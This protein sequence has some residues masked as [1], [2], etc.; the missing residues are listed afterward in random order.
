MKY[1]IFFSYF[2]VLFWQIHVICA[3]LTTI[4]KWKN[5]LRMNLKVV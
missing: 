5:I 1:G 3:T 4:A 2:E